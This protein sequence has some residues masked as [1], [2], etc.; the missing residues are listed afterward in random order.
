MT[1]CPRS[2]S[3]GNSESG[4][5]GGVPPH[6][7]PVVRCHGRHRC[8]VRCHRGHAAG[9]TRAES[10][11]S[12]H[13]IRWK[14]GC[15]GDSCGMGSRALQAKSRGRRHPHGHPG[16]LRPLR[17]P[18][19]RCVQLSLRRHIGRHLGAL[20]TNAGKTRQSAHPRQ[21]DPRVPGRTRRPLRGCV[22]RGQAVTRLSCRPRTGALNLRWRCPLTPRGPGAT[23]LPL[24]S[25]INVAP[26]ISCPPA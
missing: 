16:Q 21:G 26:S 9:R 24:A 17:R 6:T 10:K 8:G 7:Y 4:R 22:R 2:R 3:W 13:C 20:H 5:V 15:I 12:R 23:H 14:S 11:P 18:H 1:W 25:S 19:R